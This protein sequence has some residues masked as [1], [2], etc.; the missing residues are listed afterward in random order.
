MMRVLEWDD[1]RARY[2]N[3]W[4]EGM[5]S[6]VLAFDTVGSR[7][8]LGDLIA[9]FHPPSQ[10][11]PERSERFLGISRVVGLRRSED[12]KLDWIDLETEHR[13]QPPLD[14]GEAP[15]RVFLC[16][17]P[18]WPGGEVA[19]FRKVAGAAV[20]AGWT[21]PPERVEDAPSHRAPKAQPF[22]KEEGPAEPPAAPTSPEP[23]AETQEAVPEVRT[24]AGAGYSG[25]MRDPREGTW[26]AIVET[27]GARL[28]VVRLEA[29]GRHGLQLRLRDSDSTLLRA[30][31]IGLGFPFG[32]PASFAEKLGAKTGEGWWG[33]AR[34]LERMSR[35]DYLVAVQEFREGAGEVKRWT[36]E[37]TGSASPL[38]RVNPDLAPMS[39][40]GIRMMA[41]ERSRY[42]I[43]PFENAKGRLL[44]EVCPSVIATKVMRDDAHP[45]GPRLEALMHALERRPRWPVEFPDPFRARCL[46]RKDAL[47][48][49]MAA[50]AAAIA[51]L[52]GETDR[53][54]DALP[55]EQRDRV[56][57]EG[58]IY[59]LEA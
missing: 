24:F 38:H 36:D 48:A 3:L 13:F 45:R 33:F 23:P 50:R 16:C 22:P 2:P 56:H 55:E 7:L 17:D 47:D 46:V 5:P 44:L 10:K 6:H 59:G 8:R 14:A 52:T 42:A 51:V 21:P 12:P 58:W 18:G 54:P 37:V 11:H 39:Y 26:L 29:T 1:P 31:A 15:R 40:H 43:R 53:V 20:A 28:R 32:A 57:F 41:E 25:D 49:V 34:H 4:R 35:P 19:L 9:V 30:E 27:E